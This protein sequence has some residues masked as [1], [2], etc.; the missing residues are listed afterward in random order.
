MPTSRPNVVLIFSD[1]HPAVMMG[2]SGNADAHTLHIDKF[3]GGAAR[4]NNSYCPNAMYS[5]CRASVLTGL[6]PSQNS[7]HTWLD[8]CEVENWPEDWNAVAEFDTL[9]ELLARSHGRLLHRKG[10]GLYRTVR[11]GAR[12]AV[13]PVLHTARTAGA[14]AVAEG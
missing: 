14:V 10:G 6:M 7:L 12:H 4:F 5:P 2:C 13:F 1:N 11:R 8:D 9:P 3:A